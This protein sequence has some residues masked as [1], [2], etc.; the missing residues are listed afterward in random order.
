MPKTYNNATFMRFDNMQTLA[1]DMP[2][3]PS[4]VLKLIIFRGA[5]CVSAKTQTRPVINDDSSQTRC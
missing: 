1:Q 3:K 5:V 4:S 2:K